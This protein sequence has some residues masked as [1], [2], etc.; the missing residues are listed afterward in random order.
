M[1]TVVYVTGKTS[2]YINKN[3]NDEVDSLYQYCYD[4][5]LILNLKKGK[6]KVCCLK[7]LN[8]LRDKD[9]QLNIE[10]NGQFV[11]HTTQYTYLDNHL[12]SK[13]NLISNF[14]KKYKRY[15]GD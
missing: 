9:D 14:E 10:I 11:H 4:N 3:L 6:L 5:E 8:D 15:R 13:L 1:N 2:A 7:Q 12:D